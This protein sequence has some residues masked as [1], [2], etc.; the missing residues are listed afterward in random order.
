MFSKFMHR[1]VLAIVISLIIIFLG[2]LAVKTI[3]ISQFPEIAPPRVVV[4]T[5]YPGA[6]ADVLVKSV[7]FPMERAIKGVTAMKYMT[8]DDTS[9]V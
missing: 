4:E 8:S 9:A 6:S 2:V 5:A 1:P 7:L 3:P